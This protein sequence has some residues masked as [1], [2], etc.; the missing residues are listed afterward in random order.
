MRTVLFCQNPYAFGIM[1]PLRDALRRG[2]HEYIWFLT[3]NLLKSFP[4]K[5]D[6]FTSRI[7]ELQHYLPDA[8]FVPGN[9]VPHYL[10]GVKVQ[11]FHGLAGEKKGHFR[12]RHYFDLYLTQ[13]PYFTERFMALREKHQ[14]FEVVQTGWPKLD[15]LW[16][17]TLRARCEQH[18]AQL[19]EQAGAGTLLLYA[20]TF[21]PSLTSAPYLL[22]EI[23]DLAEDPKYLIQIK[24]HDLMDP[25]VV[26]QYEGLA[27]KHPRVEVVRDSNIV[28]YLLAADLLISDTSSVIYEFLLLDKPVVSYRSI[29]ERIQWENAANYR[30]LRALVE[31]N[32]QDDPFS[33]Q[34]AEIKA[35]FHPYED[36]QS[37]SRMLQATEAYLSTHGVPEGRRLSPYRRTKIR[38]LFGPHVHEPYMGPRK[39]PIS[40]L[41]I[42]YNEILHIEQVLENLKFADEIIVVDSHSTDGT[43]EVVRA[44]PKAR[45]IQRDFLNYTDQKSYALE[46]ASHDWVVFTDADERIPDALL[47]EIYRTINNPENSVSAFFFRRRFM[48]KDKVLRFSGWQSDKNYR[49]FRKS[50]CRFTNN[51]IVHET[52]DVDGSTAI[53][54][55][56]LIHYS[57]RSYEDYKGKMLRYGKMKAQEEYARGK[58]FGWLPMVL[59]PAYKFLNHFILRL[60]I[61]DGTRGVVISYLNALG[62]YSRYQELKRLG[63]IHKP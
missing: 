31:T 9:E 19:L 18:R 46:Q 45:L 58:R 14:D 23:R 52:L 15:I 39:V 56:K 2:G 33:R 35:A 49:L 4:Y 27:T 62:V 36:G 44:H 57:Y 47:D 12:I 41:L 3:G 21:S 25:G 55:N 10:Q 59:R 28:Q 53:L 7:L 51:R 29:A 8:I 48:F 50:R 43:A 60:G 6:P 63:S 54:D 30:N 5:E 16:D 17:A 32:L 40:A 11:I 26:A 24:F 22:D 61:L 42:T 34:R 20:P 38:W 13:G 1:A 37:A